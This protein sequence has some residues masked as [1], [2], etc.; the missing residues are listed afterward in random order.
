MQFL[1]PRNDVAF[2][3]IF[4][5][6]EHKRVTI[7]FLNSILEYTGER[8][9]A[10]V[11]FLNT[12]QKR[13]VSEKKDNILDILCTDQKGCKYII[14]IQ[15]E[16]VKS[17]DKRMVYYGAKTY[18]MQLGK[19]P[20]YHRLTPVIVIAILDFILFPHKKRYKSIH[21]ILDDKTFENDL[22]ELS[23]AFVELPK[24]DKQEDNLITDEDKWLYFIKWIS[25]QDAV[26]TPLDEDEFEEACHIAER[27]TWNED[28]L[29]AY[30]DAIV[31]A[32]DHQGSLELAFEDGQAKG[33]LQGHAKGVEENKIEIAQAMLKNG[34][35]AATIAKITGLSIAQIKKIADTCT[36]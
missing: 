13:V 14:E 12:E 21:K 4:G 24:F 3:K 10:D 15:V 28:E 6:H 9:I 20:S 32:T 19:G 11:Q 5:S 18:A 36:K 27:L 1:D 25:K 23:F 33:Q 35:E 29:N 8:A 34:F 17:F 30:D 26:P 7:S 31:R 2:K 22:T 16:R